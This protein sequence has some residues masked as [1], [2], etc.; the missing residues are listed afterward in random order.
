MNQQD[1][2]YFLPYQI[3]W[4]KDTSRYKIWEKSRRIGATYVQSYEDVLDCISGRLKSGKVFFS[5]ADESAAK[6]YIL[7]CEQWTK[8][9]DKAARFMGEQVIDREKDIKA[10]QIRFTNGARINALSSNPKAFRSKGG[11]LVLDEFA[12]HQDDRGLWKAARPIVTWGDP[13]RIISTHNGKQSLYYKFIQDIAAG[14]M[15]WSLHSVPI[16]QAVDEGLVDKILGRPATGEERK[17]WLDEERGACADDDVW[18]E[19]YMCQ[20]VDQASAFLPYELITSCENSGALWPPGELPD[21]GGNLYLGFDIG[22]KKDLSVIWLAEK[23]GSVLY[24]RRLTVLDRMTF[25][26]QKE[27]LYHYLSH[28]QLRRACID[29]TG[30]GMQ[31]AEEAQQDFGKYR[32]EGVNFSGAVKE[33]LAYGLRTLLENKALILPADPL[34]RDDFHS[35]RRTTTAAGNMRFDVA[36]AT[37]GHADR[38]WAAALCV[39]A[40]AGYSG[41]VEVGSRRTRETTSLLRGY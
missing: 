26:R 11:K 39:E 19:E 17:A 36:G 4:L 1:S 24:T 33:A 5:S 6:E 37:D 7:Y 14:K 18:A 2:K 35:I 29:A 28:P 23:L 41:P 15:N 16:T 12:W 10:L 30:L 20:P 27:H 8:L 3:R 13:V 38:F 34:V 40:A 21:C 25:S 9:Y 22:R 32:V 31:L